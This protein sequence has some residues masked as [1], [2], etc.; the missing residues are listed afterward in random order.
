MGAMSK[1]LRYK[2]GG[3][4]W[5]FLCDPEPAWVETSAVGVGRFINGGGP[6]DWTYE[7]WA[8]SLL[9]SLGP[10]FRAS[11]FLTNLVIVLVTTLVLDLPLLFEVDTL[12]VEHDMKF[13]NVTVNICF[14]LIAI[15]YALVSVAHFLIRFNSAPRQCT[16]AML[17]FLRVPTLLLREQRAALPITTFQ[18]VLRGLYGFVFTCNF[19]LGVLATHTILAHVYAQRNPYFAAILLIQASL[20]VL[21]CLE[22]VTHIGSPWGIQE[23]SKIASILVSLRMYL[24]PYCLLWSVFAVA[25]SFPPFECKLC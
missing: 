15:D 12:R 9:R 10:G 14:Y 7:S 23:S 1:D 6:L 5:E 2:N 24:V 22:D 4:S 3:Q 21:S 11:Q 19:F 16:L 8:T 25:A 13:A 17:P 18:N 20:A